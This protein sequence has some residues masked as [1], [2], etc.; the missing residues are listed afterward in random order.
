M[1]KPLFRKRGR[2]RKR[3]REGD[4]QT[5]DLAAVTAIRAGAAPASPLSGPAPHF[6][7]VTACKLATMTLA[8]LAEARR[9]SLATGSTR[10]AGS[11]R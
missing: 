9:I 11:E 7:I 8:A 3:G 1:K 6:P 2:G 4:R 10:A 5:E